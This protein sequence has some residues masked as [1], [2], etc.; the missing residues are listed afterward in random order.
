MMKGSG[1]LPTSTR[2]S[3]LLK[4]LWLMEALGQCYHAGK[5]LNEWRSEP[6]LLAE[7]PAAPLAVTLVSHKG[8]HVSFFATSIY[9]KYKHWEMSLCFR[10]WSVAGMY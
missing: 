6:R 7:A 9:F 8:I 10:K 5:A 2:F 1:S 4:Q 3:H